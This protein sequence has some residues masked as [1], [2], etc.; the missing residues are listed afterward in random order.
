MSKGFCFLRVPHFPC[1]AAEPTHVGNR[2]SQNSFRAFPR[3]INR[4]V[5]HIKSGLAG[6]IKLVCVSGSFGLRSHLERSVT[7]RLT[8]TAVVNRTKC[9]R[10]D[11]TEP[12]VD[13]TPARGCVLGVR[14]CIQCGVQDI[15]RNATSWRNLLGRPLKEP[16][17][18]P[19]VFDTP[20]VAHS[21]ERA[22][23]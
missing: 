9:A 2:Y 8:D 16:S 10:H 23:I 17:S 15:Q 13:H 1:P 21:I 14:A 20:S 6:P 3:R 7:S 5:K 12:L 19:N 4:V 22:C 11:E 18:L